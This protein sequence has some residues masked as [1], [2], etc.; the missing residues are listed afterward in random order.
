ME[1]M[2]EVAKNADGDLAVTGK[3]LR[4]AIKYGLTGWENFV[5]DDGK[6]IPFSRAAVGR[7]PLADLS[8]IASEVLDRS[9]VSEEQEKN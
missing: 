3:G 2:L 4:L 1:I 7:I 5:G 9:K 6:D 8:D